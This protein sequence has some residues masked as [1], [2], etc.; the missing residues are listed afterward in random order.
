[1][2]TAELSDENIMQKVK[3][4]NLSEL[5]IL[6]E[7]YHVKLFNFFLKLTSDKAASEDLTQTLFYRVIKYRQTYRIEEGSFRTWVYQMG[8][9][10]YYDFY[11]ERQKIAANFRDIHE[12]HEALPDTDEAYKEEE[13][14]KLNKA[15]SRLIPE[16]LEIII[17][18]RY[19]GLKYREIALI[20]D[21]SVTA[22]KVQIHRAL[23]QL[24]SFYFNQP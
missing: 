19:Q 6:F 9:N 5:T 12:N 15:L 2:L 16:Q 8:R 20:K 11:K 14:E 4:G 24:K 22:I 23:K 3:E 13:V 7:R 10:V 1:M 21:V 18:S 17:L